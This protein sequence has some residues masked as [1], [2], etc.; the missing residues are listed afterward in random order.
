MDILID[1]VYS[2][3]ADFVPSLIEQITI[4]P[5]ETLTVEVQFQPTDTL[6]YSGTLHVASHNIDFSL[7]LD[8]QGIWTELTVDPEILSFP[9]LT[10]MTSA[11]TLEVVL[12]NVG[13]T[14]ITGISASLQLGT[15]FQ[16]TGLVPNTIPAYS[17]G[18]FEVVA[19]SDSIGLFA[20][21]L[22]ITDD[23]G[24]NLLVAV[25]AEV[26]S[27]AGEVP[28]MPTEYFLSANFPNPFN[29]R[30]SISFDVPTTGIVSLKVYNSLGQVVAILKD[31]MTEAGRH[32]VAFEGSELSSGLYFCR[33]TAGDF[34]AIRKMVLMK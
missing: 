29:A 24:S 11:E 32:V 16:I 3:V 4:S 22:S 28:E 2:S 30:T 20:D 33:M 5:T 27:P 14:E 12:S 34:N 13:N 19:V 17:S 8:G 1:S 25:R 21:T 6:A 31:G 9:I 15:H 23:L 26:I 18:H 7:E 10:H